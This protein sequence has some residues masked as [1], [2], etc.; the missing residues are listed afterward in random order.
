[1]VNK[2]WGFM[3]VLIILV[4]F[5]GLANTVSN[6]E[7]PIATNSKPLAG[8][9]F[10]TIAGAGKKD[11]SDWA[12][13]F[14]GNKVGGLQ[15]AWE[16]TGPSGTLYIGSGVYGVAQTLN[17]TTA[18]DGV[19]QNG[20]KTIQGVDIGNGLPIFKGLYSLGNS[21]KTYFITVESGASYWQLKDFKVTNY[22]IVLFTNGKNVSYRIYNLD[23][24]YIGDGLFLKGGGSLITREQAL[25]KQYSIDGSHDI[26]IEDCDFDHYAKRGIRFRDGNYNAVVRRC[27]GDGGGPAY[28]H[29]DNFQM[30]IQVAD[31]T[32]INGWKKD[33]VTYDY[34]IEIYDCVAKNNYTEVNT[35]SQYWN[36]DGFCTEFASDNIKFYRCV[37]LE[38][39]DGGWDCK[40]KNIYLYDCVAVG[41]K[42]GFR[43][44]SEERAELNNCIAI[45]SYSHGGNITHTGVWASSPY[46]DFGACKLTLNRCTIFNNQGP[47]VQNEGSATITLND[48]IIG[49]D[50]FVEEL[51][52]GNI[53]KNNCA[54]YSGVQGTNPRFVNPVSNWDGVGTNWNSQ[55]YGKNKGY[56][57]SM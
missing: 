41:N 31:S 34:N 18:N 56:Y 24:S 7:N 44:W 35:G 30:T 55:T 42:R 3:V 21:D 9:K 22:F 28:W 49:V 33:A 46:G 27:T 12:N 43:F 36:G 11:G 15:A 20:R 39:T 25:K 4:G 38:S 48:C 54:E 10:M 29:P 19:D 51:Y 2:A 53:I 50:K 17:I 45:N 23:A 26:V 5:T 37:A 8:D 32:Q 57:Q 13:A 14:A 40:S 16:A 52:S 1:M 47:Q 6:A